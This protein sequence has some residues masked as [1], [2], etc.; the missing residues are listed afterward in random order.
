MAECN[1]LISGFYGVSQAPSREQ[2]A[3]SH[4]AIEDSMM[5]ALPSGD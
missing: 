4:G 5:K 3:Q 1:V 2:L